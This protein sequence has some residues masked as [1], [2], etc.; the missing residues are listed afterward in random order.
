MK[1]KYVSIGTAC[2][3]GGGHIEFDFEGGG[4]GFGVY[5]SIALSLSPIEYDDGSCRANDLPIRCPSL[6]RRRT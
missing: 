6:E 2:S 5:A 3:K 1:S 4:C